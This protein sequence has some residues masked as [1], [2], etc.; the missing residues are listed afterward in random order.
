MQGDQS[1]GSF[2]AV[3]V[4]SISSS[5]IERIV[6]QRIRESLTLEYKQQSSKSLLE[7][8]AAMANTY[9][10]LILV[11]IKENASEL[12]IV[13]VSDD[14][15]ERLVNQCHAKLDPP[16]VPEMALIG[17]VGEAKHDVLAVRVDANRMPRPLALDGKIWTRLP[18]RNAPADRN[19]IRDLFTSATS[20][21]G[22]SGWSGD[23]SPS[24]WHSPTQ[25]ISSRCF[26][27]RSVVR[28]FPNPSGV[29]QVV[30]SSRRASLEEKLTQCNLVSWRREQM[31]PQERRKRAYWETKGINTSTQLSFLLPR[32]EGDAQVPTFR[33]ILN[34][35]SGTRGSAIF[36][37][38]AVY[39]DLTESSR[40]PLS[41]LIS[42]CV[43]M[44]HEAVSIGLPWFKDI[45]GTGLWL[46]GF[47]ELQLECS[48]SS[49]LDWL[50]VS[51]LERVDDAQAFG[52]SLPLRISE[53]TFELRAL[54]ARVADWMKILLLDL[55]FINFEER[56]NES[57]EP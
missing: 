24:R 39:E 42:L 12:Q 55:G 37:L 46:E 6:Q 29:F 21:M 32:P 35:P 51:Q 8:I 28:V 27:A 13:G 2:F 41:K 10:G 14:A 47:G 19:R 15:V 26:V 54:R 3:P 18:G 44:L 23:S 17:E 36:L 40:L 9:G 38:D 22:G 11:G 4:D 45:F 25:M 20:A 1:L 34:L 16:S 48:E 5:F 31:R 43:T 50:E 53:E 30:D 49:F 56:L 33:A 7:T 57:V 52:Q